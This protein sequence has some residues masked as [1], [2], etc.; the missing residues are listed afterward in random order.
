M[1]FS[2]ALQSSF[3]RCADLQLCNCPQGVLQA[4]AQRQRAHSPWHQHRDGREGGPR[5]SE[6]VCSTGT[7]RDERPPLDSSS[8]AAPASTLGPTHPQP[9][10]GSRAFENLCRRPGYRR[11]E[12]GAVAPAVA[13]ARASAARVHWAGAFCNRNLPSAPCAL[14]RENNG[15]NLLSMYREHAQ[16]RLR[17]LLEPNW[18]AHG[19]SVPARPSPRAAAEHLPSQI[20]RKLPT[21]TPTKRTSAFAAGGD[22][23]ADPRNSP[24][25]QRARACD[26]DKGR[27]GPGER[28]TTNCTRLINATMRVGWQD[29]WIPARRWS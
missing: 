27:S 24:G 25:H 3:A 12:L 14:G 11:E 20:A 19:C 15:R 18:L 10:N 9:A 23:H 28:S 5:A 8:S 13:C 21:A 26:R 17:R 4:D 7:A 16:K 1:R 2:S 29:F 6:A 22:A